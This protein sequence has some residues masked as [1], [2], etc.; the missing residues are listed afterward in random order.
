VLHLAKVKLRGHVIRAYLESLL[1]HLDGVLWFPELLEG[2][3]LPVVELAVPWVQFDCTVE[4]L[5]G[6]F[7]FSLLKQSSSAIEE[8]PWLVL[9]KLDGCLE[10]VES[11]FVF[12]FLVKAKS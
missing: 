1:E 8:C 6:F 12:A 5:L 4:V 10:S 2:K 3:T 9:V 11:F 7:T